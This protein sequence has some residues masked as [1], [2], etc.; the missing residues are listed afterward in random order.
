MNKFLSYLFSGILI[1]TLLIG[2]NGKSSSDLNADVARFVTSSD[3]VVGYG[4]VNILAIKGKAQLSQ[5]PTIGEFVNNQMESFE[6]SLRLT[7]KI[8][9]ALEGPLNNDG[10]PK[11]AYVF[12]SVENEDSTLQMFKEMGFYF[13][14]VNDMNVS[15]DMN[16]AVGFNEHTVVMVSGNFGDDPKD[17]LFNAFASFK[18]EEK[19]TDVTEILATTT[20]ILL[21]GDLEN[22]YQTS[23]TSLND[24]AEEN[25]A[26]IKEMV[27]GGHF[28]MTVDF[29]N[30]NLTAKMDFSR[31]NDKMKK[32]TFFKDKVANDVLNN[33]GPGEPI[34]AMAMSLD[35]EK[36]ENLMKDFSPEA[37]RSFYN[38]MGP[39]GSMFA[40]LTNENLS[41]ILNGDLGMMISNSED[42]D[43]MDNSNNLPNSHLYLGL[44]K[45]PQNMK[46]LVRTFASEEVISDLG[47]G[48]FKIEN[49]ML[50][51]K[52]KSVVMH[53][54]DTLKSDFEIGEMH[55]VKGLEDFGSKPFSLFVDLKTLGDSEFNKMK[56]Q[57]DVMLSIADYL[58][59]TADNERMI[60]KLVLKDENENVLKQV[61]DIYKDDLKSRMGNIS[62]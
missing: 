10:I 30:G 45:N 42:S 26:E 34:M 22:L 58:T 3:E 32:N 17:K 8:H 29:N 12:M 14:E 47:E 35:I 62:F 59:L 50:L 52:D 54:N 20:D 27:R 56:G 60:F 6:N 16:M 61:I 1:S 19:D 40:S 57:F 43:K 31:V 21:A 37:E 11:Y 41:D 18:N 28:F 46:D 25:Q 38:S 2:C 55:K 23:N 36:L 39:M 9:Y 5:I 24:L 49:S 48:Y 4:Y 13:E 51:M 7:D 33:L 15:F 53:S 44:G